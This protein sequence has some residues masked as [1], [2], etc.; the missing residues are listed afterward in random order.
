VKTL[1]ILKG[2]RSFGRPKKRAVVELDT[3]VT[4]SSDTVNEAEQCATNELSGIEDL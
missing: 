1:R 2:K 4:D 3:C